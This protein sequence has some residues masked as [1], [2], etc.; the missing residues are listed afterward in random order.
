M[1]SDESD[2]EISCDLQDEYDVENECFDGSEQS[3]K[4]FP[5][6]WNA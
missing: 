1:D 6:F 2:L 5:Y 4:D 3:D